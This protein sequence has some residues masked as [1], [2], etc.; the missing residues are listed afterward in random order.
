MLSLLTPKSPYDP[1]SIFY[2]ILTTPL[3]FLASSLYQTFLWL[4]P[5]P[6]P[7][8]AGIK[9]VCISDTH[10]QKR[11]IPDADLLIHA[12]DLC[13]KGSIEE[14]QDQIEWLNSL[15]HKHKIVIA[16][17]HD[18]YLDP[19]SRKTLE[20][21]ERDGVPDWGGVYYLERSSV[22]LSFPERGH[23]QLKIYGAPQIPNCGPNFAFQYHRDQDA[24]S[25]T[26]PKVD[27]LVTHSPPLSHADL[28]LGCRF[29]LREL[30]R[31]RP[32]LH[33]FGHV[34]AG[35]GMEKAFFDVGQSAYESLRIR[36]TG[37]WLAFFNPF[38]W[39]DIGLVLAYGVSGVL[40]SRLW[41]GF[42][43]CTIMVNAALMDPRTGILDQDPQ[44]VVI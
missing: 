4:R 1:P 37:S 3:K 6:K 12:G 38:N 41:G 42:T 29:L 43:P 36:S 33:V 2:T 28:G 7:P 9:V 8:A 25:S 26:V 10:T 40:W 44:V 20:P 24:W 32:R 18:T 16:G 21:E 39:L 27:I 19:R 5:W 35:H 13:N 34:H 23:R 11:P 31:V 30:W 15:P 14:L 22:T 17:N